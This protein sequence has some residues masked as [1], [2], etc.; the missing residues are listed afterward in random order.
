MNIKKLSNFLELKCPI[1]IEIRSKT[2]KK[3]EAG[4]WGMYAEDGELK[5]HLIHVYGFET[6]RPLET[7]IAHELIHAWQEENAVNEIHG[8]EFQR[9]A[10]EIGPRFGI[11]SIYNPEIDI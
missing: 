1:K 6:N 11:P 2:K 9:L 8:P 4:Y 7:L 10:A 3:M 5:Y